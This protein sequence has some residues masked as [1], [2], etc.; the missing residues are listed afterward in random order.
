[1]QCALLRGDR[2]HLRLE[3]YPLQLRSAFGTAH[4]SSM[5]RTN[6]LLTLEF[7]QE[8][9]ESE[10]EE[11]GAAAS[12]PPLVI[13]GVGE[14]GMPPKKT[15]CYE[16]TYPALRAHVQEWNERMK[17][18]AAGKDTAAT[19]KEVSILTE[20]PPPSPLYDPFS[21]CPAPF[22]SALRADLAAGTVRHPL[23]PS[24]LH[25]F[26]LLDSYVASKP[27]AP[28]DAGFLCVAEAAMM[29][30]WGKM[31][32]R[33]LCEMIGVEFDGNS[34]EEES[35][36]ASAAAASAAS[37]ASSASASS[38]APAFASTASPA[39]SSLFPPHRQP[40]SFYTVGL[41]SYESM[42]RTLSFGL[43][44]TPL[45]KIKCNDDVEFTQRFLEEAV[46]V[47]STDPRSRS[48]MRISI[49]ANSAWS[50][51][52]L[53]MRFL[54]ILQPHA[55]CIA[56]VEQPFPLFRACP[57]YIDAAAAARCDPMKVVAG[58]YVSL[59]SSELSAWG[60]VAA[61]YSASGL[62]IYADESI[63]GVSDL[64]ALRSIL[65]GVNIKLEKAGGYRGALRLMHA[66][67]E[68]GVAVWLGCMVGST[69]NATQAAHLLPIATPDCWGD[70][71][72]NLLTNPDSDRFR[73][74]MKW[75]R[76]GKGS[77][78]MTSP[79][80]LGLADSA[81]G[82]MAGTGVIEK[83]QTNSNGSQDTQKQQQK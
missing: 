35:T 77:I 25:A 64:R 12:A 43:E 2:L 3:P 68:S 42:Q 51:P 34:A 83:S 10:G 8:S 45:I 49:D 61:A 7:T 31:I 9:E 19:S 46:R 69:P 52:A 60:A 13:R 54:S 37:A 72:G 62:L 41:D 17:Q 36:S 28:T 70:L 55:N 20:F 29:D 32:S 75:I 81:V 57:A 33:P 59:S 71:D 26:R 14:A 53:A 23:L 76:D 40:R 73:G 79:Q 38:S 80:E 74:G 50:T 65:H 22:Y 66:A 48:H 21:A 4:S 58:E 82:T 56:M 18:E 47:M 30:A 6:G 1:M 78:G 27:P 63:C 5:Q 67:R 16:L 11:G 39:S 24:L 15:G 44:Y